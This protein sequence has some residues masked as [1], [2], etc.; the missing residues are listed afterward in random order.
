MSCKSYE[1][2]SITEDDEFDHGE[3]EGGED[4][5]WLRGCEMDRDCV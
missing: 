5:K 4:D 2:V 1:F 3:E